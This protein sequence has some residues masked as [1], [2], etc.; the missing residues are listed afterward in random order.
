MH[1]RMLLREEKD[2]GYA[3]TV[4]NRVN[5]TEEALKNSAQLV[6][7]RLLWAAAELAK[8]WP[9]ERETFAD[10]ARPHWQKW[11]GESLVNHMMSKY[12]Y[13]D[14]KSIV[15]YMYNL[16]MRNKLLVAKYLLQCK[17]AYDQMSWLVNLEEE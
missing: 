8:N 5:A 16:D 9:E 6:D 12:V 10:F 1:I 7:C 15:E 14:D 13:N 2:N 11:G 4:I 3:A 17:Q